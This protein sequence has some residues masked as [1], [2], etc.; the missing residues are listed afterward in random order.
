MAYGYTSDIGNM[1]ECLSISQNVDNVKV[2][3]QYCMANIDMP[4]MKKSNVV[5]YSRKV[6]FNLTNTKLKE[7]VYE[8]Y[9]KHMELMMFTPTTF[10]VGICFPSTCD[11]H[12]LQRV[13]EKGQS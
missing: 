10:K 3:G 1:D 5:D 11:Y 8:I 2:N 7:S 6:I 4:M 13:L 12:E 9:A